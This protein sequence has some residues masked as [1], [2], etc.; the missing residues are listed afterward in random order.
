MSL[1]NAQG[2]IFTIPEAYEGQLN[3]LTQ[4]ARRHS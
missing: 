3:V 1:P 2:L 4:S